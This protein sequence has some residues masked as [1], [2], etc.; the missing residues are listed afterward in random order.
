MRDV[1]GSLRLEVAQYREMAVFAQFGADIDAATAA[2][3]KNG[4]GL[5]ELLKQKSGSDPLLCPIRDR[6]S[7]G[8]LEA[9]CFT[10]L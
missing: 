9:A 7:S 10:K 4:E 1:S 2:M 5:M 8:F 6:H 3:L